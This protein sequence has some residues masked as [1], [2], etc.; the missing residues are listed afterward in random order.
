MNYEKLNLI[1]ISNLK[2]DKI[3]HL[4]VIKYLKGKQFKKVLDYNKHLKEE[5]CVYAK[6]LSLL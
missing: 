4:E 1:E 3:L 2:L 6:I 5:K